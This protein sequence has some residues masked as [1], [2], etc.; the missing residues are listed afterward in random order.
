MLT[1]LYEHVPHVVR[2]FGAGL[3]VG[4]LILSRVGLA[5]VRRHG[6]VLLEVAL[7]GGE[8][9]D[10]VGLAVEFE[11]AHPALGA[12]EGF[13]RGDVVHDDRG[14]GVARARGWVD[15]VSGGC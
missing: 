3:N 14:P 15:P 11:L 5:F 7:V 2:R 4:E 12:L 10:D 13:E 1:K 9:N 8:S 6:A